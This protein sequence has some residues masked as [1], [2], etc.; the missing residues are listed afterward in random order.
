MNE[1]TTED[2]LRRAVH[3]ALRGTAAPA[4]DFAAIASRAR[5][6]RRNVIAGAVTLAV[7][8]GA[9]TTVAVS[10][11]HPTGSRVVATGTPGSAAAYCPASVEGEIRWP[12]SAG[13]WASP[14]PATGTVPAAPVA[15][16]MWDGQSRIP[17]PANV[18]VVCRYAPAPSSKL[19]GAGLSIDAGTVALLEAAAN[20]ASGEPAIDPC[21]LGGQAFVVFG[22]NGGGATI[23]LQLTSC[24]VMLMPDSV[25]IRGSFLNDIETL[26]PAG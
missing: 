4:A 22:G 6:H 1:Q 11:G 25:R 18:V 2:R 13:K 8:A 21:A 15:P 24:D 20:T 19:I 3:D 26:A 9:G 23:S 7:L 10:R 12:P 14:P 16:G 5:R 17:F